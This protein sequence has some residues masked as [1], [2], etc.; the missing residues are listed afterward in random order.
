L[1]AKVDKKGG[2][3]TTERIKILKKGGLRAKDER[4]ALPLRGFLKANT[5]YYIKS[6]E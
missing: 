2:S 6:H 3:G 5:H 1:R 4:K